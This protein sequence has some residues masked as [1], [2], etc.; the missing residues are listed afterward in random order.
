MTIERPYASAPPAQQKRS[1]RDQHDENHYGPDECPEHVLASL[2]LTSSSFRA[3]RRA[4]FS[5]RFVGVELAR[6]TESRGARLGVLFQNDFDYSV[7][8]QVA[9]R[10]YPMPPTPWLMTQT[11]HDLLFLHWPVDAKM[12]RALLPAGLELDLYE[13]Q[14]YVAVT[15]F[16]MTNVAPRGVPHCR[17][18]RRCRK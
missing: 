11:W 9:H 4:P 17:G 10:P 1:R 12:L 6:P 2:D 16:F 15:P 14:A 13:G 18:S 8:D 3:C 7:M 5:L